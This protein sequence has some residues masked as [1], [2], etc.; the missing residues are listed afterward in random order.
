MGILKR[1]AQTTGT[2]KNDLC[3]KRMFLG[4]LLVLM[5]PLLYVFTILIFNSS[6][7]LLNYLIVK[8]GIKMQLF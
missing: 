8:H 7:V 5:N 3:F 6:Q 4:M 1:M 2:P